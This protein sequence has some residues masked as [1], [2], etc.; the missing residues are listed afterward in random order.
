MTTQ[1]QKNKKKAKPKAHRDPGQISVSHTH[2]E[3][4]V[5]T[6]ITQLQSDETPTARHSVMT[7]AMIA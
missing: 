1:Q 7:H 5:H 6:P 2:T 4:T 3:N